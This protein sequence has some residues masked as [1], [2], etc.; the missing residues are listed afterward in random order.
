MVLEAFE[1][2]IPGF[3]V[4]QVARLVVQGIS[5]VK[6]RANLEG[7]TPHLLLAALFA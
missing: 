2:K 3:L 1:L 7:Q 4:A 6:R 5:R